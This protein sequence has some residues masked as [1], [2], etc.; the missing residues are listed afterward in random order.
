MSDKSCIPVFQTRRIHTEVQRVAAWVACT[1]AG[2]N[3]VF[4]ENSITTSSSVSIARL[5]KPKARR[6]VRDL[7]SP[8]L[9]ILERI[10]L[11]LGEWLAYFTCLSVN[12][13]MKTAL[14]SAGRFGLS[15][16]KCQHDVSGSSR[17]G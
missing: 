4:G 1:K 12:A 13:S 2:Y 17:L 16:M 9:K 15:N 6:F 3:S 8:N 11:H 14:S 5:I 7:N 10:G